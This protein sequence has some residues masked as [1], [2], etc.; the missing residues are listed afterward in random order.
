MCKPFGR[1]LRVAAPVMLAG[2]LS[3][4]ASTPPPQPLAPVP[5]P[6]MIYPQPPPVLNI[7]AIYQPTG[8]RS[9]FEDRTARHVGDV[10]TIVLTERTDANKRASTSTSKESSIDFPAPTIFG[11]PV[12]A[13]GIPILQAQVQAG[14]E[15]DGE[16]SSAQSNSLTGSITVQVVERHPNGNLLVRGD[17]WMTLNQGRELVSI[18]GIVRPNDVGPDNTVASTQ[19][20]DARITYSGRGTIAA[21]NTPGWAMWFV[22]TPLWPF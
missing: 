20:A 2:A 17:K 14:R 7:G 9:L 10:L 3:S 21:A 8:Q 11:A 1:V 18:S 5:A 13:N 12:T 19:V 6:Q 4:C 15:F 22:N 16:G